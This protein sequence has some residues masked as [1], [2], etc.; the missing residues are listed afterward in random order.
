MFFLHFQWG[1]ASFTR[2]IFCD[3]LLCWF[4]LCPIEI[5]F[6]SSRSSRKGICKM[7]RLFAIYF[8]KRIWPSCARF[9]EKCPFFYFS[10][11]VWRR[12]ILFIDIS[13][14]IINIYIYIYQLV[15]LYLSHLT[16]F[17]RL[18]ANWMWRFLTWNF[19]KLNG[20]LKKKHGCWWKKRVSSNK[21]CYFICC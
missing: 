7:I 1:T 9:S 14:T 21:C 5:T 17:Q 2:E 3:A 4:F 18:A 16:I 12:L 6:E 19:Q 15:I 8:L 20:S 13:V 10:I 11:S